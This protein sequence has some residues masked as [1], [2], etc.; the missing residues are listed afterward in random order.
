MVLKETRDD[1]P[2]PHAFLM[3]ALRQKLVQELES[4][5]WICTHG[6]EDPP[7]P[8]P[9]PLCCGLHLITQPLQRRT[10]PHRTPSQASSCVLRCSEWR[11]S[12]AITPFLDRCWWRQPALLAHVDSKN[13]LLRFSRRKRQSVSRTSQ[14]CCCIVRFL[15]GEGAFTDCYFFFNHSPHESQNREVISEQGTQW[16]SK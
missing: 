3:N 9:H 16:T 4:S 10:C 7:T 15:K 14:L 11:K 1:Y 6:C 13:R 12:R 8:H 5:L 2:R